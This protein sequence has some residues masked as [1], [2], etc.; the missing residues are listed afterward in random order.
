[1]SKIKTLLSSRAQEEI[2]EAVQEAEKRTSS[3]VIPLCLPCSSEYQDALWKGAALGAIIAPT[4]LY[5]LIHWSSS[6]IAN[7]LWWLITGFVGSVSGAS[8]VL[9][10]PPLKRVLVGTSRM[11]KE[12]QK[13][14]K[15]AFLEHEV[16]A[17]KGRTGI[18][19]FLSLFERQTVI[20]A[21]S[22]IHKHVPQNEWDNVV[23]GMVDRIQ[24]QEP[25]TAIREAIQK[26][27]DLLVKYSM[28][29]SP[30]DQNE[31]KDELRIGESGS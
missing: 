4:I 31:L 23:H 26:C 9:F 22:G 11:E 25:G 3:E 10:I 18:L 27:A 19:I 14:A 20:L 6:W 24:H 21:D 7:D 12:V 28:N 8:M 15:Q 29:P 16:F 30:T 2:R 17:T 1:M 5:L 13:C